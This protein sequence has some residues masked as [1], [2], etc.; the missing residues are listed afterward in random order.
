MEAWSHL[1][2][3]VREFCKKAGK[4]CKTPCKTKQNI[5]TMR[6]LNNEELKQLMGE[7]VQWM[8]NGAMPEGHADE[9]MTIIEN[10]IAYRLRNVTP[11]N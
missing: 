9:L 4:N 1:K 11:L 10:E 8:D 5:E 2:L 6:Q 7:I 3:Y